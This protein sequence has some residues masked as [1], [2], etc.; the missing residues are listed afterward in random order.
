[1]FAPSLFVGA[2]SGMAFGVVAQQM[3]GSAAGPVA[4]QNMLGQNSVYSRVPYFCSDQYDS[5]WSIAARLPPET[6]LSSAET[7]HLSRPADPGAM[8]AA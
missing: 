2:T 1:V 7:S 8:C 3:F 4:A 5:G 6:R